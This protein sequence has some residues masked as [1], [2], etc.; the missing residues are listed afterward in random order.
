MFAISVVFLFVFHSCFHLND[1]FMIFPDT[2]GSLIRFNADS[3][4]RT[5]GKQLPFD[6]AVENA[7]NVL[8]A[9]VKITHILVIIPFISLSIS[10]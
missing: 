7:V 6:I 9:P 8:T 4:T 5:E 3:F 2:C 10:V 1:S